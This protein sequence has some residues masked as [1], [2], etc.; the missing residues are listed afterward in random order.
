MRNFHRFGWLISLLFGATPAVCKSFLANA[1]EAFE[2]F[3]RGTLYL[4]HATSLRMSDIGY[5]SD[6]QANLYVS[7][8]S[9]EEYVACLTHAIET[10]FPEYE[11]IGVKVG[12][13]YRQLNAN[14]LQI[15]NEF[16]SFIRPKQIAESGEKPTRALSRRGV[17]YVEVRALDI[18]CDDAVGVSETQ[19][20]L[21][22][23]LLLHCLL[24]ASPSLDEREYRDCSNN[25]R[26]VACCGRDPE[27]TLVDAGN[28]RPMHGWALEILGALRP[29]CARLDAG[30]G[31]ERYSHALA[32]AVQSVADPSRLP[33]SRLLEEMRESELP[34]FRIAMNRSID[35]AEKFR[36]MPLDEARR[37]TLAAE[38]RESLDR[39]RAI[40]Q[41]DTLSFDEYLAAY[42]AA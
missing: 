42:F 9:L 14:L 10:P 16:Y 26:L 29:V 36:A 3:D 12:D 6:N 38:A 1:P 34:F 8:D 22:E 2:A 31:G 28:A 21:V 25:Q 33:S 17:R 4:P 41:S 5:K 18:A 20:R 7:Y 40:E 15:E 13:E 30:E 23:A 32:E 19:L 37:E 11:K 35:F 27:L 24:S 39:Q